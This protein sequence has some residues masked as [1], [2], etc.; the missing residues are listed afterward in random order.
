MEG[1]GLNLFFAAATAS[2]T[3][4]TAIFMWLNRREEKARGRQATLKLSMDGDGRFNIENSGLS[5]ARDILIKIDGKALQ[6][7]PAFLMG[8]RKPPPPTLVGPGSTASFML[9]LT[10]D[11]RPPFEAELTWDD[12]FASGRSYRTTLTL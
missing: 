2:A 9:M 11:I 1:E 10:Y 7:H 6:E 4:A 3:A 5:E 12:D 8:A